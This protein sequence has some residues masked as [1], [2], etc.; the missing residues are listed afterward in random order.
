MK[1]GINVHEEI[2]KTDGEIKELNKWR[3]IPYSWIGRHNIVKI[4]VSPNLRYKS[5]QS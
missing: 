1:L 4:L 5:I 3:N 2:Y